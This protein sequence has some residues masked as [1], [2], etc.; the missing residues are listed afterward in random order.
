[1]VQR[2]VETKTVYDL[3]FSPCGH[4]E[5]EEFLHLLELGLKGIR[6]LQSTLK[7]SW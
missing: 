4:L 7:T 6:L 5:L 1:M 3:A 2:Y